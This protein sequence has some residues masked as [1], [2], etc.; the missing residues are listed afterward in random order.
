MRCDGRAQ[1]SSIPDGG[2][3]CQLLSQLGYVAQPAAAATAA[4]A[5]AASDPSLRCVIVPRDQYSRNAAHKHDID[6]AVAELGACRAELAAWLREASS[7]SAS[8]K[9]DEKPEEEEQH[10]A[11]AAACVAQ[12]CAA[13]GTL[14]AVRTRA[15]NSNLDWRQQSAVSCFVRVVFFKI[16]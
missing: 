15:Q 7:A 4:A 9:G 13:L 10:E 5:A 11:R 3:A 2:D 14:D 12:L 16:C 6:H 1:V 8:A